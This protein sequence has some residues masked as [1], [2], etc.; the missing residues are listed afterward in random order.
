M[1]VVS[2][3][4]KPGVFTWEGILFPG[5]GQL[6]KFIVS[7]FKNIKVLSLKILIEES[8]IEVE[9]K[10]IEEK[11]DLYSKLPL[12]QIIRSK[13]SVNP[14]DV[15][16]M[17]NSVLKKIK[18]KLGED[19]P[20]DDFSIGLDKVLGLGMGK[21]E[22]EL[23]NLINDYQNKVAD[24][25]K[26]KDDIKET[27]DNNKKYKVKVN[28]DEYPELNFKP[29][30][31]GNIKQGCIIGQTNAAIKSFN[32][33]DETGEKG[34]Q[35]GISMKDLYDNSKW[36]LEWYTETGKLN[37]E[38]KPTNVS[39]EACEYNK[40]K[41]K[42]MLQVLDN[43][44]G[45]QQGNIDKLEKTIV[46][47]K[48]NMDKLKTDLEN[49]Y[50]LMKTEEQVVEKDPDIGKMFEIIEME[51]GVETEALSL[52]SLFCWERKISQYF[53]IDAFI[54]ATLNQSFKM[55]DDY[56]K[57]IVINIPEGTDWK[58]TDNGISF[59]LKGDVIDTVGE[60]LC[61]CSDGKTKGIEFY[62]NGKVFDAYDYCM[63]TFKDKL[64]EE[65]IFNKFSDG[66]N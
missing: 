34:E 20:E 22:G 30:I 64:K 4:W 17:K 32:S 27:Y 65:G 54:D 29:D 37:D 57:N 44:Q 7:T 19:A 16:S 59:K 50:L 63:K 18:Q 66:T 5:V 12:I 33:H 49:S 3:D 62:D 9:N 52:R 8:T 26:L 11:E 36:N 55:G 2:D 39:V 48:D 47:S 21:Y 40:D 61:N 10:I 38:S 15:K 23:D 31:K 25:D 24:I 6:V 60:Q 14:E 56:L 51:G 45:N 13:C 1:D 42:N 28:I 58:N 35:E 41:F 53:P 43:I 46:C